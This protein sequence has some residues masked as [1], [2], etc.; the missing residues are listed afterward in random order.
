MTTMRTIVCGLVAAA[1]LT[2]SA[3]PA[4]AECAITIKA[5]YTTKVAG[6]ADSAKL[7]V[8][9][10]ASEARVKG[11][12]WGKPFADETT[13]P[14][15]VTVGKSGSMAADLDMACGLKRQYRF[16]LV[17]RE[18]Q[19][20]GTWKDTQSAWLNLPGDDDAWHTGTTVDLGDVGKAF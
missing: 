6:T 2:A 14:I 1:G 16:R 11:G 7:M 15:I 13:G 20:N 9:A 3:L 10:S 8:L 18:L 5:K 4:R 17:L 12:F 19:T